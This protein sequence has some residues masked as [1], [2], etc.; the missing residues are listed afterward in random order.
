[1]RQ[2]IADRDRTRYFLAGLILF[3]GIGLVG[4]MIMKDATVA[5]CFGFWFGCLSTLAVI[6]ECLR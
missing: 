5:G 4:G 3:F 6:K 2:F 1:M